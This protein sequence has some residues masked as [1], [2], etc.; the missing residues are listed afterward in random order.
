MRARLSAALILCSCGPVELGGAPQ[1]RAAVQRDAIIGGTVDNGDPEVFE[2]LI[3]D[4]ANPNNGAGCSATLIGSKTLLTAA[5]C[6][7]PRTIM[8]TAIDIYALNQTN[9]QNVGFNQMIHVTK[10]QYHPNWDPMTLSNDMGLA[11]LEH[12]PQGVNPKPW[13]TQAIDN[14][15]GQPLRAAGYGATMGGTN[16][17]GGGTKREVSLT[18]VQI[19]AEQFELGDMTGHGIC[20]GD[21]GGP[22]FY[23]FGDG[24]ERI[25]GVHSFTISQDCLDGA[26]S[27]TD[28]FKPFIMTWISQN[29]TPTCSED[30]L[31]APGCNPPDI[32]CVCAADGMCTAA[33]PDLLKDPD[34]PKDCVTNGVCATQ[35]CPVPD[36]DCVPEGGACARANQCVTRVCIPDAQHSQTYCSQNCTS[37]ADCMTVPNMECDQSAHFC[38]YKQ[39][40]ITP[41]GSPCTPGPTVCDQGGVCAGTSATTS[42]CSPPCSTQ[43]DCTDGTSTCQLSFDG[44]SKYCAEPPKSVVMIPAIANDTAT[45]MAAQTGCSATAGLLPLLGTAPLLRRRRR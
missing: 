28:A 24:V 11:L 33:C 10:M 25:V 7:D 35:A 22:S 12:S 21:S 16:P 40:Q 34:C 6:V 23:T 41:M 45:D 31:C 43:A 15:T 13:N 38:T 26:D 42:Y 17:T 36:P 14:L 2:L 30:G 4:T 20:H 5:H 19:A 44:T 18:F 39:V 32:D 29:E 37:N 27:R 3:V 8:A 1:S 9:D